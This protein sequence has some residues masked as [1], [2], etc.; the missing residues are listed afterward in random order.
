MSIKEKTIERLVNQLANLGCEF[1]VITEDGTEYGELTATS[2]KHK[3]EVLK[4]VDY[5]TVMANM[6]VGDVEVLVCPPHVPIESLRSSI[7]GHGAFTYGAGT[8]TT[9]CNKD[10]GTVEVLRLE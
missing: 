7:S 5:K 8:F 4:H 3:T 1:K 6:G 10:N 9:M 2:K